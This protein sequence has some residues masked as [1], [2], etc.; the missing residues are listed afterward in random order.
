[1][2]EDDAPGPRIAAAKKAAT[3]LVD[4][5]PDGAPV[6]LIVY[7]TATD[8]SDAARAAGCQDIKT[9][10]PVAPVDKAAFTAAVD[11]VASGYTPL[12]GSLRA[13]AGAL[14]ADGAPEHRHRVR[15][16]RHLPAGGAVRGGQGDLR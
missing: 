2:N 12:A 4:G 11:G 5:L 1:M 3:T 8:D 9:L 13:A 10:V 14:P 7:G 6:G 16:G 15:R